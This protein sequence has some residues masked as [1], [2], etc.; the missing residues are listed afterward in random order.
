[1]KLAL[2]QA[3]VQLILL[4]SLEKVEIQTAPLNLP[5]TQVEKKNP[6]W[7]A[8]ETTLG[9]CGYMCVFGACGSVIASFAGEKA[10]IALL[11]VLDLPSGAALIAEGRFP[12]HMIVLGAAL[13]FGGICIAAQNMERLRM[14]GVKWRDYIIVRCFAAVLSALACAFVFRNPLQI[15]DI[16]ASG[17]K[18]YVISLFAAAVC[19]LPGMIFLS[20]NIFLNKGKAARK[21][22][23]I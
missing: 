17:G 2:I 19:V 5:A 10:G 9:V 11:S 21:R 4:K 16:E 23:K 18:M 12:G 3:A 7:S 1:M 6:V 14:F 8:V 20:K 13:G 22:G 15:T